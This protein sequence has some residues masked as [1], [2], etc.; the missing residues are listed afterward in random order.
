MN[1]TAH[2]LVKS[3]LLLFLIQLTSC[4]IIK[5]VRL[6]RGGELLE[7]SF[8]VSFPFE[9]RSGMIVIK[10]KVNGNE[11]EF[12]LDSGAPNLVSKSMVEELGLI[13]VLEQKV[14]DASGN[15]Q[16]LE[17]VSIEEIELGGLNFLNTG[18][19]VAD[20]SEVVELGCLEV[21]GLIG[22]NLMRK[23]I[24]EIDFENEIITITSHRDSLSIPEDHQTVRFYQ[25]LTGTPIIDIVIGTRKDKN[26]TVDLGF[27]GY[28][29]SSYKT[30]SALQKRDE[31][32]YSVTGHG[33]SSSSLY[34]AEKDSMSI[35]KIASLEIG[36]LSHNDQTVLFTSS[37]LKLLGA[38]YFSNFRMIIDWNENELVLI[39]KQE[40]SAEPML[41][42]GFS[43]FYRDEKLIVGYLYDNFEMLN[44]EVS[45]GDQ[46]L[47]IDGQSYE[48]V[49]VDMWCEIL[50]EGLVDEEKEEITLRVLN[51]EGVEKTLKLPKVDLLEKR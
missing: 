38:E 9:D 22:A 13:P 29:A 47:S 26:V 36:G 41:G 1:R 11:Y 49:S 27:N 2:F 30:F 45:L 19:A 33:Y 14:G 23:A 25:E 12:I 6:I 5:T 7:Q 20:L 16:K 51:S 31:I 24:W 28:Y 39:Q 50:D 43:P 48:S 35:A 17:F 10:A 40:C 46:I 42:F 3:L 21:D 18:A 37:G 8:K 34:G 4:K 15:K 32:E 44:E